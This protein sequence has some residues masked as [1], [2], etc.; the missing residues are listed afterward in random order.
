MFLHHRIDFRDQITPSGHI[1]S[2]DTTLTGRLL[3][4]LLLVNSATARLPFIRYLR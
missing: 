2:S 4:V 3:E 1:L